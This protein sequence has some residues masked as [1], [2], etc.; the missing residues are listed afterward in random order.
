MI[1]NEEYKQFA[2]Q[3]YDMIDNFEIVDNYEIT[4]IGELFVLKLYEGFKS[5][6]EPMSQIE[7]VKDINVLE[8]SLDKEEN[9]N[10]ES[11]FEPEITQDI[12]KCFINALFRGLKYAVDSWGDIEYTLSKFGVKDPERI[13]NSVKNVDR[14]LDSDKRYDLKQEIVNELLFVSEEKRIDD[15]LFYWFFASYRNDIINLCKKCSKENLFEILQVCKYLGSNYKSVCEDRV[16]F[17][18]FFRKKVSCNVNKLSEIV[19]EFEMTDLLNNPERYSFDKL[20]ESDDDIEV[21]D[22]YKI[23]FVDLLFLSYYFIYQNP[24]YLVKFSFYL[25][26]KKISPQMQEAMYNSFRS[27]ETNA[28]IQFEYEWWCSE[29]SKSLNLPFPFSTQPFDKNNTTI[30]DYDLDDV[31]YNT[32]RF[33]NQPKLIVYKEPTT[34][35]VEGN[36]RIVTRDTIIHDLY[37]NF[38]I[39]MNMPNQIR[40]SFFIAHYLD[41]IIGFTETIKDSYNAYGFAYILFNSKYFN[42]YDAKFDDNFA[43]KIVSIF[44]INIEDNKTYFES[45]AREC[46]KKIVLHKVSFQGILNEDILK[47]FD[48]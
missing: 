41:N 24:R 14:I 1:I 29:T 4:N 18:N 32:D 38:K 31:K 37:P 46:A 40:G 17:Y 16:V 25:L 6:N 36:K 15:F 48:L 23:F 47:L 35:V 34:Q 43:S 3:I 13:I 7:I 11:F 44:G 26:Y 20:F 2:F 19:K 30:V 45:K 28:L 10:N 27:G 8:N 39:F 21:T 12:N 22:G 33:I 42:W 5:L 9:E